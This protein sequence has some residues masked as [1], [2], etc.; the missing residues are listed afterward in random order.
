MGM[1]AED[2]RC[3]WT[4]RQLPAGIL[5]QGCQPQ[6][7][8]WDAC[9]EHQSGPAKV[10]ARPGAAAG[11]GITYLLAGRAHGSSCPHNTCMLHISPLPLALPASCLTKAPRLLVKAAEYFIGVR[12]D[13]YQP[14]DVQDYFM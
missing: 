13:D 3:L 2:P 12:R 10:A 14:S 9:I 7:G 6:Q 4:A 1:Q 11:C 8:C 5:A